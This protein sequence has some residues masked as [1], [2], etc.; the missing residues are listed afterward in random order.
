MSVADELDK[1]ASLKERGLLTD[2]EFHKEKGKLL[3]GVPSE[4]VAEF[5]A[6]SG[7]GEPQRKEAK[8]LLKIFL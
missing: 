3:A 8:G 7:A 2:E 1:L 6:T 4:A 5:P